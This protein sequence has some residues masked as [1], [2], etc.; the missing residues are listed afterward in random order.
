MRDKG[1]EDKSWKLGSKWRCSLKEERGH[2]PCVT[3]VKAGH[4]RDSSKAG[5]G[6]SARSP[7]IISVSS[8]KKRSEVVHME[9]GEERVLDLQI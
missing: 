3:G 9:C 8:M 6:L 4:T 7:L 5:D 2:L 1:P